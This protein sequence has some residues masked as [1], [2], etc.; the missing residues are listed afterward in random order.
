M[1]RIQPTRDSSP[2]KAYIQSPA[3]QKR[4]DFIR[5]R[6]CAAAKHH[7]ACYI[8]ET[9][10][11]VMWHAIH[12][13]V[14]SPGAYTMWSFAAKAGHGPTPGASKSVHANAR[15]RRD[16]TGRA[17]MHKLRLQSNA[18]AWPKLTVPSARRRLLRGHRARNIYRIFATNV[19]ATT[20]RPWW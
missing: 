16:F 15:A 5:I 20:F 10:W 13:S 1:L 18:W 9:Q 3:M 17:E 4:V 7:G 12:S 14:D 19:F 11:A 2:F 6:V 8:C